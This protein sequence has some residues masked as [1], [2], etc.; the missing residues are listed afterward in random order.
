[1]NLALGILL[2]AE[3]KPTHYESEYAF[4]WTFILT[5]ITMAVSF[6]VSL[7][8]VFLTSQEQKYNRLDRMGKPVGV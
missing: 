6:L 1:M 2:F 3:L 5:C 4:G 8:T 7:F